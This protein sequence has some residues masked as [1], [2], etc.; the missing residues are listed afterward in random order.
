MKFHENIKEG[1][2]P[3]VHTKMGWHGVCCGPQ[4]L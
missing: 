4:E 1:E 2:Y 3:H